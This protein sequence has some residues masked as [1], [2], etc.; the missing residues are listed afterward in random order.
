MYTYIYNYSQCAH[1][2]CGSIERVGGWP[3]TM[4]PRFALLQ[5]EHGTMNT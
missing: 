3:T 1:G 2:P 4:S 5:R